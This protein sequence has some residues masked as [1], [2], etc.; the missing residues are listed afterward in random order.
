MSTRISC[1]NSSQVVGGNQGGV[2]WYAWQKQGI[3]MALIYVRE[4]FALAS[5]QG[6]VTACQPRGLRQGCAP[7]TAADHAD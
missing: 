6:H 1:R 5:P 2:Q 4:D 7:G 3:H